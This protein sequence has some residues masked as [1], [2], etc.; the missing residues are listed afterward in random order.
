MKGWHKVA[1]GTAAAISIGAIGYAIYS[2]QQP[3][4]QTLQRSPSEV[5]MMGNVR[6]SSDNSGRLSKN[7]SK[8]SFSSSP[9]RE[10]DVYELMEEILVEALDNISLYAKIAGQVAEER[11]EEREDFA[12]EIRQQSNFPTKRS[13]Q[14]AEQGG[15]TGVQAA[16]RES[17]DVLRGDEVQGRHW[18]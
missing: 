1:I 12:A 13:T 11:P 2:A 5:G 4:P 7:E 17:A 10:T 18:G 14:G 8:D 6:G 3:V 9:E 16:W 15:E